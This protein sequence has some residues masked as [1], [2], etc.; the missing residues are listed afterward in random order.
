MGC[1]A[2]SYKQLRR[3]L[4]RCCCQVFHCSVFWGWGVLHGHP[5]A[6]NKSGIAYQ[7]MSQQP[8]AGVITRGN[9]TGS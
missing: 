1:Q 9:P 7:G 6:H 3:C 8:E 4:Y 2:Y 5:S